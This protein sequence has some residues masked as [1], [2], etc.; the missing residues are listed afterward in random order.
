[1]RTMQACRRFINE[2]IHTTKNDQGYVQVNQ[3]Q[4]AN[5]FGLN[6][7][8]ISVVLRE[9]LHQGTLKK[10]ATHGHRRPATYQVIT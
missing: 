3:H 10:I 1:M 8:H 4:V 6:S 7:G 2:F 5:T 9:L